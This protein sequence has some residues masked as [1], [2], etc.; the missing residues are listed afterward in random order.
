M[1]IKIWYVLLIIISGVFLTRLFYLQVIKYSY[2]RDTARAGQYKEYEIPAARGIIEAYN[3]DRTVPIVLNQSKYTLFADPK[4]IVDPADAASKLS[5]II[6][7]EQSSI[8]KSMRTPNTRYVVLKKKLNKEQSDKVI[9]LGLKGVGTREEPYRT[10]PQGSLASQL[11][12]FVNGE[13]KGTYGIEQFL[14]DELKGSPGQLKAITDAQ[15]IPLVSNKDNVVTEPKNGKRVVLTID[16]PMQKMA[17]D[18]LRRGLIKASSKSGSILVIEADT[19]KIRAMANY[20]TYNPAKYYEVKDANQ[21]NNAVVS[22]PLEIGSVMKP[23]TVAA[24]LDQN[25][26][27]SRTTYYDPGKFTIDGAVVENVIESA[28]SGNRRIQD[29]LEHSLNT[30]ATWLLMQMGGGKINDKG[31]ARWHSYMTDHYRFGK[32]TGIEQG[33]EAPGFIP[34]DKEGY[35]LNITYANTSFGQAVQITPLQLGAAISG[36]LNGGTYYKP[37]LVDKLIDADGHEQQVKPEVVS[38]DVVKPSTGRTLKQFMV[39][40]VNKNWQIY[41]FKSLMPRY[42][43]GAKTGTAQIT[44]PATGKYFDDRYNGMFMGFVGGDRVKYVVIVRVNEPHIAGYAGAKA[45]APIF[46]DLHPKL[47]NNFNVLP[48]SR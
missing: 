44:N 7:V 8:E 28:G 20:P 27:N 34:S 17:E 10:Y 47:I 26:V 22:S 16:L 5:S 4:Y 45:A 19:G 9:S 35:G 43:I 40:V 42:D 39:G 41:S 37:H 36:I 18:S 32:L 23:L 24:A 2:Y 46:A 14:D 38:K 33:Y 29:I 30:G 6:E 31:R 13:G 3:G 15:G 21:F 11:L 12:G 25:V 1:R 48:K